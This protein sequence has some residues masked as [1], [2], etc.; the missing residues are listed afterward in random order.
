MGPSVKF[1][2]PNK[3]LISKKKNGGQFFSQRAGWTNLS[4]EQKK[5]RPLSCEY[6]PCIYGV[7]ELNAFNLILS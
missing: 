3:G 4:F 5:L 6:E 2:S 7:L 1:V